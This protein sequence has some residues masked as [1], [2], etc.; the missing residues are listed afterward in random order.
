MNPPNKLRLAALTQTAEFGLLT[1]KQQAF[2]LKL[3]AL[4]LTTGR[5]DATVAAGFAYTTK[6]PEILGAELMGQRKIK[7]VLDIHFCRSGLDSIL[8]D[9]RVVVKQA[10][11]QRELTP[12]LEKALLAF[13]KYTL[14]QGEQS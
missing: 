4:G 7:R 13:E 1:S 12:A 2:V 14:A 3:V 5:Y 9:L 8:A 10:R 6:N 11:R